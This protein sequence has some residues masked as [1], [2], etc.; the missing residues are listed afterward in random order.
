MFG[1]KIIGWVWY[2]KWDVTAPPLRALPL[3]CPCGGRGGVP[4]SR[5][6]VGNPG[7]VLQGRFIIVGMDGLAVL[8]PMVPAASGWV[9][10]ELRVGE[11]SGVGFGG[12]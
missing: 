3:C 11:A 10:A 4:S 1:R 5:E 9:M 12:G 2:Q 7:V 6:G 8:V